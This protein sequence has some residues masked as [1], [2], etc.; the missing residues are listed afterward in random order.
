MNKPHI[1]LCIAVL[2][3]DCYLSKFA[4]TKHLHKQVPSF[5][6]RYRARLLRAGAN[7]ILGRTNRLARRLTNVCLTEKWKPVQY[8]WISGTFAYRASSWEQ[9][10]LFRYGCMVLVCGARVQF[11]RKLC[12]CAPDESVFWLRSQPL[13]GIF[14]C[15]WTEYQCLF[16]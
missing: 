11:Q 10:K 13:A 5:N 6:F 3:A 16:T 1:S 4:H 15:C 14:G 9:F 7:F 12:L 8:D 2:F